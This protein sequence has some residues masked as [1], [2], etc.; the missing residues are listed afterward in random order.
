M[1]ESIYRQLY[2]HNNQENNDEETLLIVGNLINRI[3]VL[4]SQDFNTVY[5]NILD[6]DTDNEIP[7]L[8]EVESYE[9]PPDYRPRLPFLEEIKNYSNPPDY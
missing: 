7:G 5:H 4:R 2:T 8:V 6:S 1:S 3:A 9:Q